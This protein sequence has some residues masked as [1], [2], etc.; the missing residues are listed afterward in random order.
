MSCKVTPFSLEIKT[1]NTNFMSMCTNMR[2]L[3]SLTVLSILKQYHRGLVNKTKE[4]HLSGMLILLSIGVASSSMHKG[5]TCSASVP[6]LSEHRNVSATRE[7]SPAAAARQKKA[8]ARQKYQ[9]QFKEDFEGAY[10]IIENTKGGKFIFGSNNHKTEAKWVQGARGKLGR[11]SFANWTSQTPNR[12][13]FASGRVLQVDR[14]F[15][16]NNRI[17]NNE[18]ISYWK[19]Y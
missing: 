19:W 4:A 8:A 9:Q 6:L 1:M 11:P 5:G 12:P 10:K 15:Q 2:K 7:L 13:S 14:C 3:L 16:A 17:T 18:D